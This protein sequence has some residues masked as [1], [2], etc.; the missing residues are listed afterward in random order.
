VRWLGCGPAGKDNIVLE[1]TLGR[2]GSQ[3]SRFVT[4]GLPYQLEVMDLG[5][6]NAETEGTSASDSQGP[7]QAVA[8][9]SPQSEAA[10]GGYGLSPPPEVAAALMLAGHA[11]A[12]GHAVTY[13]TTTTTTTAVTLNGPT[14]MQSVTEISAVPGQSAPAGPAI[15]YS[16][17]Q[18]GTSPSGTCVRASGPGADASSEPSE[19]TDEEMKALAVARELNA[20][21]PM[22]G[23]APLVWK[24]KA[25]RSVRVRGSWDGWKRDLALEP[26]PG[27]EFR[28]MMVLPAGEYEC[29]FIIDEV[30]TT[31]DDMERTTCANRNN[32]FKVSNMILCP[33]PIGRVEAESPTQLALSDGD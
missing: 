2:A 13:T 8:L 16:P 28:L 11:G 10:P 33:L 27:G 31:S 23:P 3:L 9:R 20:G 22:V 17:G 7:S 25:G 29:K 14:G 6:E 24:G 19:P 32:V 21:V 18:G 12:A 5:V 30:W 26:S 4:A 15:V 1:T